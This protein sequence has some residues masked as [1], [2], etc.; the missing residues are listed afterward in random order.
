MTGSVPERLAG[1]ETTIRGVRLT[2]PC[3]EVTFYFEHTAPG[4]I[5]DFAEKAL[6]ALD[7]HLT[8]FTAA[9]MSRPAPRGQ[10]SAD[11][12]AALFARPRI[13][14]VSWMRLDSAGFR[15]GIGAASLEVSYRALKPP[16][17]L[18]E[19]VAAK[20][21][22]NRDLFEVGKAAATLPLSFVRATFPLTHPAASPR[23]LL[24]F[25]AGLDC[26]KT[27][28]F[29]AGHAGYAL[30]ADNEQGD[31]DLRKH[32][33]AAVGAA[34][35]RHPGLGWEKPGAVT[36]KLLKYWPGH[37]EL[38]PR[39]KRVQWLTFVRMLAIDELCGSRE[40]VMAA[41]SG[42]EDVRARDIGGAMVF[43]AG[44]EPQIG[45]IPA[46]DD[47]PDYRA[48][49]KALAPARLPAHGGLG[50]IFTDDLAQAWLESLERNHD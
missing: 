28:D 42:P 18:P 38:L 27:P 19:E 46:G 10:K 31:N 33:Q 6:A 39:F 3:V 15:E 22:Q 25:V 9:G 48:V 24:D 8:H 30:N 16:P 45:D 1:L 47:L 44:E 32:M 5:K 21:A 11:R 36:P 26:V 13:G 4:I 43:R 50:S 12:W 40:A 35:A 29:V 17:R 37:A 34:L 49:A 23:G 41:V 7:V 20:V 2:V 14:T